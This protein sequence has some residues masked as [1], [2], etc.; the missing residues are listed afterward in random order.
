MKILLL[1]MP[2]RFNQWQNLEMPLGISYIA[3]MLARASHQVWIKDYEVEKFHRDD[4]AREI[5]ELRPD[6]VGLSFR[7]SSYNSAKRL[8]HLMKEIDKD[9]PVVLG[10]H[11]VSAFAQETLRDLSADFAI[12]GEGEFAMLELIGA[13]QGKGNLENI[14][15]LV[16]RKDADIK[17]NGAAKEIANLDSL[18]FPAWDVLSMD[19]YLTASVLSTRGC[20]FR[21]IFCDKGVSSRRVRFRSAES[22]LQE[23]VLLKEKYGKNQFYFVDDYFLLNKIRTIELLNLI[24]KNK[25]RIN[26]FCQSRVDGLDQELLRLAR[27]SGCQRITFGVETGD[28]EELRYIDK[29]TTLRQAEQAVQLTKEAGIE[30]RVNFMV[31]F[32]ISTPK[33]VENSI[34]FAARLKADLYRFFVV[35][36]LPNTILWDRVKEIHPEIVDIS[37]DKF[38]FYSSSFDTLELK[39]KELSDYAGAAYLYVLKKPFLK[40]ITFGLI[41]NLVRVLKSILKT[42]RIRGNISSSFPYSVNLLLEEWFLIRNLDYKS[43]LR[44]LI[45]IFVLQS[46]LAD[47]QSR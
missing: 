17:S 15:G 24:I 35:S 30:A 23:L 26:W 39:K 20:P 10:G 41:P 6:L 9:I 45:R 22:V 7:S 16:Y 32:P 19:R 2:I 38:D 34:K 12:C 40:E 25:L 47:E 31:G 46:R 36:P 37:W 28:E 44:F 11:H 3:G 13:L 8:S 33:T 27:R 1:N 18:S 21:C 14:A 5:K 42:R 29:K 43:R 4:F